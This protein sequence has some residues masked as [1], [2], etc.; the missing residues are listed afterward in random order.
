MEMKTEENIVKDCRTCGYKVGVGYEYAKCTLS[1]CYC[2]T[3]R[4]YPSKCGENFE[5]WTPK[6]PSKLKQ[7][8]EK[9]KSKI[10]FE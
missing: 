6:P 9:L 10:E 7:F 5:G 2:I 3:E 1:G 4:R 8:W